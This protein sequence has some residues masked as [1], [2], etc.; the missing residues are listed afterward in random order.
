MFADH[1]FK[2][3]SS[4]K[5]KIWI[6]AKMASGKCAIGLVAFGILL[7][8]FLSEACVEKFR[9]KDFS[10]VT[11]NCFKK[12]GRKTVPST[13]DLQKPDFDDNVRA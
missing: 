3:N 10:N 11:K 2:T 7:F 1:L 6:F 9:K 12:A 4:V 13:E 8:A 5:S